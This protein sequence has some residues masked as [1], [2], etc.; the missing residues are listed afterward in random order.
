MCVCVCVCVCVYILFL[1]ETESVPCYP[2][3][4]KQLFMFYNIH[5]LA[6][7]YFSCESCI[8]MNIYT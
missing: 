3:P 2:F 1:Y 4:E 8:Y 6:A 5:S 7:I